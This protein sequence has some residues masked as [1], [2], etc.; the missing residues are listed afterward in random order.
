MSL[1]ARI[2]TSHRAAV[3]HNHNYP[4]LPHTRSKAGALVLGHSLAH[5][6]ASLR[7]YGLA[8]HSHGNNAEASAVLSAAQRRAA[9]RSIRQQH[10]NVVNQ[11]LADQVV[12]HN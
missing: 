8:R 4:R 7:G 10:R 5:R 2:R 11:K 6:C 3:R 12:R 1:L 9:R